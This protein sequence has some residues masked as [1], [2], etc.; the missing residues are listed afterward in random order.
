MHIV[1]RINLPKSVDVSS[2]YIQCNEGAV[3]KYHNDEQEIVCCS[4]GV[5]SSNTYFNSFYESFYSKY[6]ELDSTY[7]LLRLEGDFK[8][9]VYR[10]IYQGNNREL[11]SQETF[12]NC[13]LIDYV[14][15]P[16]PNLQQNYTPQ[17]RLYFE[18]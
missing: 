8:V 18:L 17:G 7:Y 2:L 4:G 12:N 3:L 13:Q 1:G 5:I 16:L 14:K 11:I 15:I 6:T 9:A 10:E